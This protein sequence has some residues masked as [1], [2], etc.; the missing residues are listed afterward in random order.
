MPAGND[1]NDGDESTTT[2][3]S[4]VREN[5]DALE[6]LAESDLPVAHIAETLLGAA[7][8]HEG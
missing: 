1:A 5:Q 4:A 3:L 8:A 6:D 7:E 2:D